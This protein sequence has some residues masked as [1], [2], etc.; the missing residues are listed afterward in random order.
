[1]KAFSY[2]RAATPAEAIA[3]VTA[4][5]MTGGASAQMDKTYATAG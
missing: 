2:E 3:A 4:K 5:T 1:M